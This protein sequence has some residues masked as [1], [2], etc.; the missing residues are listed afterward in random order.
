M[1]LP[2]LPLA[3]IF[4]RGMAFIPQI[5]QKLK[6]SE[7]TQKSSIFDEFVGILPTIL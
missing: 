5:C 1:F 2:L 6:I 3:Q 7:H 4:D